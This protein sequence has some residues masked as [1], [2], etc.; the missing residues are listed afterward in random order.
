MC[1]PNWHITTPRLYISHQI[2]CN[3]SH[4]D[5]TLALLHNPAAVKYNPSGPIHVPDR[6]AARAYLESSTSRMLR[7]GYGRFL[8]SLRATQT[9]DDDTVPFSQRPQEL[10]GKVTC[11]FQRHESTPGP[12]IPD[13]GFS[14]LPKY[15][16]KGYAK[17]ALQALMKY[18]EEEKGTKAFAALTDEEN[19]EAKKL[20]GRLGFRDEGVRVVEGVVNGGKGERM[21]VWTMG[22]EERELEGLGLGK[23]A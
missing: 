2:T 23:E 6:D 16:G 8:V 4:I 5:F 13:I 22:V 15:H 20:L 10:I 17:E 12:Q 19:D 11:Q 14:F 18:Y 3:D 7:T 1:D 9:P 21:S